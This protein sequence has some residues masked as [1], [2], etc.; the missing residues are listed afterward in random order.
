[1]MSW[2]G[3][4]RAGFGEDC[5]AWHGNGRGRHGAVGQQP[6]L[7][8]TGGGFAFSAQVADV[9]ELQAALDVP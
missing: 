3:V 9:S 4:T 2:R 1:M 6:A 5:K 7:D 8:R